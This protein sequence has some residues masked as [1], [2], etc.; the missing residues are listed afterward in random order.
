MNGRGE[1]V[2]VAVVPGRG[3]IMRLHQKM[4]SNNDDNNNNN[5]REFE[6]M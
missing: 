1:R 4:T 6:R 2:E 5:L 3:T